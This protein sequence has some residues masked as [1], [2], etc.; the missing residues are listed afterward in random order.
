MFYVDKMGN[1]LSNLKLAFYENVDEPNFI[2]KMFADSSENT[3]REEL[4]RVYSIIRDIY[5]DICAPYRWQQ[6]R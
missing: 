2:S 6:M 3:T 4:L 1:L 5:D